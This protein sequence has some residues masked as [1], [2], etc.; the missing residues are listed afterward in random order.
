MNNF[1]KSPYFLLPLVT[2]IWS[3]NFVISKYIVTIVPPFTL[4][5]GRFVVA[6]MILLPWFMTNSKVKILEDKQLFWR[7]ILMALTGVFFFNSLI[8][9]GLQYTTAINSVLIN[10]FNPL[11]MVLLSIFLLKQK[12]TWQRLVGLGIS[13]IGVILIAAKGD[14]NNLL[15]L[16]FN[17]G[18]LL[19][20]LATF[21]WAIYSI[22]GKVVM[23]KIT[24]METV[25]LATVFGTIMLIPFSVWEFYVTPDISLGW[26][27]WVV[28]LYL[29][30][31]PSIVS[32]F[33]WLYCIGKAGIST[34]ANFYNLIPV[35][36][37]FMAIIFL[38]EKLFLYQLGGG[39]LVLLGIYFAH[40]QF[41]ATE[42]PEKVKLLN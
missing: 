30:V 26:E 34:A 31:F 25:A 35:F 11:V 24:P 40:R 14:L 19:V 8:Y 1:F 18:D 39:A 9:L 17:P 2:F 10:S 29:G 13:L 33:L 36:G 12:E 28:I 27:F 32:H 22:A 5:L 4:N 42:K 3:S 21:A 38:K 23:A 20:I 7:V 6:T 16:N 15:L 37:T 41:F